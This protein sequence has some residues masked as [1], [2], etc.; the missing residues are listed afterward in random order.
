MAKWGKVGKWKCALRGVLGYLPT[1]QSRQ[2]EIKPG[3]FWANIE[4][5]RDQVFKPCLTMT[6][7]GTGPAYAS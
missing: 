7:D 4:L 1:P 2:T 5:F 6:E 3:F